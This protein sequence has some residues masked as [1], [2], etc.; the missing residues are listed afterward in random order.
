MSAD[1][2]GN[3]D[4]DKHTDTNTKGMAGWQITLI[5]LAVIAVIC[6]CAGTCCYVNRAKLPGEWIVHIWGLKVVIILFLLTQ[7]YM[8]NEDIS[9]T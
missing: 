2:D 1:T 5:C 8:N 6:I 3:T 4:T 9:T 7:T